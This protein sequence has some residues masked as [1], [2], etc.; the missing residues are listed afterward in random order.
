[1]SNELGYIVARLILCATD[2][3]CPARRGRA[4][5]FASRTPPARAASSLLR[6]IRADVHWE[7][8]IGRSLK[9]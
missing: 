1:M 8:G 5:P 2:Y 3:G 9:D 4:Y 7:G 6:K